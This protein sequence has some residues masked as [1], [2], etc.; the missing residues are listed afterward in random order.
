MEDDE[1]A[2]APGDELAAFCVEIVIGKKKGFALSGKLIED[3][4]DRL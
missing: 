3:G 1:L 2:I 4:V